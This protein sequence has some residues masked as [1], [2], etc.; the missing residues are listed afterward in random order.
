M[1]QFAKVV[2]IDGPSGSGKSTIAKLLAE[3]LG[4]LYIDTGA[5]YRALGYVAD[6]RGIECVEGAHLQDFLHSIDFQYGVGPDRLVVID[7][8]NL[9]QK[10]RQHHVSAL[11]SNISK[12][13]SVRTYLLDVQ[14][15][16]GLRSFSVMEGRDI[17]TVV[18]PNAFCKIFLTAS[19]EE[20]AT[21]RLKQLAEKGEEHTF[22]QILAD[23]KQRDYND[24]HREMAPLKQASDAIYFDTTGISLEKV[25]E[26]LDEMVQSSLKK[27][28]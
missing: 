27:L 23:V 2:A 8:E 10:I 22:E 28:G 24:T 21:R 15:E 7:G 20:R 4:Y 25:L 26:R 14:R 18:F 19:E 5:M 16:L 1:E 17:G 3:R 13:P 6:Q 9:T 12:L 11:A